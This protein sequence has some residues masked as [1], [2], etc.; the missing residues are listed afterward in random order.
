MTNEEAWQHLKQLLDFIGN[1][2]D[3]AS[4]TV[5]GDVDRP[6]KP[7]QFDPTPRIT[8]PRCEIQEGCV[9]PVGHMGNCVSMA[10]AGHTTNPTTAPL[11]SHDF[12]SN[13]EPWKSGK[14]IYQ[15]CP[16][17]MCVHEHPVHGWVPPAPPAYKPPPDFEPEASTDG[18][19][20]M[21]QLYARVNMIPEPALMDI[22][23]EAGSQIRLFRRAQAL[24]SIH[25]A[26]QLER[27]ADTLDELCDR[28]GKA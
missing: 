6:V 14:L 18:P 20:T 4:E 23:D 8:V 16:R 26:R 24:A 1:P 28:Y 7:L 21:A 22:E 13:P 11:L 10:P 3:G 25:Q 9:F 12:P 5:G 19:E 2:A 27:I 17:C 15:I